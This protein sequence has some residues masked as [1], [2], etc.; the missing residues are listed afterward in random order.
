[1]GV[2]LVAVHR[3]LDGSLPVDRREK[4]AWAGAPALGPLRA[5]EQLEARLASR[6]Q[7][8]APQKVLRVV[9]A[10]RRARRGPV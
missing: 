4:L 10:A 9:L 6:R 5:R 1:M 3:W 2:Q 8:L 7:D